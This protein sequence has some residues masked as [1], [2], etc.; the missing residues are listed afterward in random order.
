MQIA[1][2]R[3]RI[4]LRRGQE[5]A[6]RELEILSDRLRPREEISSVH[7]S[8]SDDRIR[9]V[10]PCK[11][12]RVSRHGPNPSFGLSSDDYRFIEFLLFGNALLS[13]RGFGP[14][15]HRDR[16]PILLR[17]LRHAIQV[18]CCSLRAAIVIRA[19]LIQWKYRARTAK[20]TR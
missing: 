8:G 16:Q 14:I 12:T 17:F 9:C 13:L 18:A 5:A 20:G 3:P 19:N 7:D 6:F 10:K 2:A 15:Y 4:G 1:F 11:A